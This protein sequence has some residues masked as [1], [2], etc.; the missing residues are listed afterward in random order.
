MLD[1]VSLASE[2]VRL[3]TPVCCLAKP[4][5]RRP[6]VALALAWAFP[7]I[8]LGP[9]LGFSLCHHVASDWLGASSPSVQARGMNKI[10]THDDQRPG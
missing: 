3:T 8:R 9:A 7:D 10:G 4:A 1:G 2:V 5:H 6:G